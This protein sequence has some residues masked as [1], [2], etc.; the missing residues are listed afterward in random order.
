ME[1]QAFAIEGQ[2]EGAAKSGWM[3][4][5]TKWCGKS[6]APICQLVIVLEPLNINA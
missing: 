1:V 5:P 2:G 6:W 4:Q 3:D